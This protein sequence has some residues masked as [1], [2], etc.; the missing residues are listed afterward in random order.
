[1]DFNLFSIVNMAILIKW[2]FFSKNI[3]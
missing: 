2:S 1:L 3:N